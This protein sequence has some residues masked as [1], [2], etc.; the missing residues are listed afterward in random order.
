MKEEVKRW[1]EQANRDLVTAKNSI[2][3]KDYYAASYWAQQSAEKGLKA[4]YL[5]KFSELK[6]VHN[7]VVLAKELSLPDKLIEKCDKLNPIYIDTRYPDTSSSMPF[8]RYNL[9][10]SKEDIK[11]AEEILKWLKKNI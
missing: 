6:K 11:I 5:K 1:M 2:K 4:Y 9:N 8:T 10:K 7:L 3:S